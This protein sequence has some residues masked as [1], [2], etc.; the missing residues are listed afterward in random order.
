MVAASLWSPLPRNPWMQTDSVP[1]TDEASSKKLSRIGL[2]GMACAAGSPMF[3][4]GGRGSKGE[5]LIVTAEIIIWVDILLYS[6][7]WKVALSEPAL[8]EVVIIW[9]LYSISCG[10]FHF[11][12][13]NSRYTRKVDNS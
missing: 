11:K 2:V 9:L 10:D 3:A 7:D 1:L 6:Y 4:A 12:C 8:C 5:L 13:A